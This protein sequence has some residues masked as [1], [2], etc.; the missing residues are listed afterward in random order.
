MSFSLTSNRAAT[1]VRR[2]GFSALLA[3]SMVVVASPVAAQA[4]SGARI[5]FVSTERIMRDSAPAK[6]AQAKIEKDFSRRDKE[7]QELASR[8][9]TQSERFEK[10]GAVM[11][12]A[13]RTRRQR[14]LS[15]MDRDLQRRQREF[16]E[17]LNQRR[18]EELSSVLDKANR[19]IKS[20]AER[21]KF[22][23]ILQD[24]VYISPRLDITDD[25]IKQLNAR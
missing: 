8:L 13:D 9:R 11:S 3:A 7:I 23:L 12:D 24:A 25:V 15:D 6:A 17:D 2:A 19:A 10:D 20:I 5:G 1:S 18:N 4:T 22:D 21:E 14:E 16:R